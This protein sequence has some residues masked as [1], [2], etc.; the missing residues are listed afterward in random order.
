MNTRKTKSSQSTTIIKIYKYEDSL[1]FLLPH[2]QDQHTIASIEPE[3]EQTQDETEA[4]QSA[5]TTTYDEIETNFTLP[6]NPAPDIQSTAQFIHS[7]I[8]NR[9]IT[10]QFQ[11][12]ASNT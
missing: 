3:N 9:R 4:V 1:N 2:V 11:P 6:S 5:R 10:P 8:R 12:S 7:K